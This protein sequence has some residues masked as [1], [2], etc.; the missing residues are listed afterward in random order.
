MTK[1]CRIHTCI[2]IP[3]SAERASHMDIPHAIEQTEAKA[4]R[5]LTWLS[6]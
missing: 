1:Q 5:Y 4:D 3:E 2:A 6:G